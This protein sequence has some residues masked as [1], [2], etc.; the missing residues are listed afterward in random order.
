MQGTKDQ[1]WGGKASVFEL[2]PA[3]RTMR[4]QLPF[5]LGRED[6]KKTVRQFPK[7]SVQ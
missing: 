6:K 1:M 4:L 5:E 2:L 7:L 3:K